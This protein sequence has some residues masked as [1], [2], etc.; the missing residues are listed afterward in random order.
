MWIKT[1]DD[2]IVNTDH[3]SVIYVS[4]VDYEYDAFDNKWAVRA[5]VGGENQDVTLD[6]CENEQE[7]KD[8]LSAMMNKLNNSM[9]VQGR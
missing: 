4:P 9:D 8:K 1:L 3:I 5:T 6:K 2:E 7:A